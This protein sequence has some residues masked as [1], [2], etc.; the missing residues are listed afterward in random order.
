MTSVVQ[1]S[2]FVYTSYSSGTHKTLFTF[3]STLL[4]IEILFSNCRALACWSMWKR[5]S[6]YLIKIQIQLNRIK[7]KKKRHWKI[8]EIRQKT[9]YD[10]REIL[11]F[12]MRITIQVTYELNQHNSIPHSLYTHSQNFS[13][14]LA[15][16]Q[17]FFHQW[18]FTLALLCFS[19]PMFTLALLDASVVLA[20]L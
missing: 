8:Y 13:K 3:S 17:E 10:F 9:T 19:Q 11:L 7:Y 6:D 12:T 2:L 1:L 18:L 20:T 16:P 4:G 5:D 14:S 15:L